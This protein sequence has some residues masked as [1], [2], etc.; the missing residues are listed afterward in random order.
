MKKKFLALSLAVLMV[1]SLLP[2]TAFAASFSKSEIS[3]PTLYESGCLKTLDVTIQAINEGYTPAYGRIGVHTE[4]SSYSYTNQYISSNNCTTWPE[5]INDP[6]LV[7]LST[8]EFLW[9]DCQEHTVTVQ[10]EDGEIPC[11]QDKTYVVHLWTR[12]EIIGIYPDHTF[13]NLVTNANGKLFFG[14]KEIVINKETITNGTPESAKETNH[15]YITVDET[16]AEG[17]NVTVTVKPNEGYQL[18]SLTC[19][20]DTPT[21][22]TI[23]DVLATVEGFPASEDQTTPPSSAWV[24]DV[25]NSRKCYAYTSS[26]GNTTVLLL[27]IPAVGEIKGTYTFF[28]T[29]TEVAKGNNYYTATNSYGSLTFNMENGILTSF[30]FTADPSK[31]NAADYVGTYTPANTPSP[32]LKPITPAKQTDGTYQFTMPG[33]AVTVTA[34]FEAATPTSPYHYTTYENWQIKHEGS[35]WTWTENLTKVEDGL[36]KMPDANWTGSGFNVASDE[37]PIK[38][39]WYAANDPDVTIGEEVIAPVIVDVY[40]RV[41]DDET[42]KIGIGEDPAPVHTHTGVKQNGQP[43]T[44]TAAG[45]KDYYKCDC[46]LYFEDEDC[47]VEIGDE[48]ALASW[49]TGEGAIAKLVHT[50]TPVSAQAATQTEAGFKDYYECVNCGKYYEDAEGKIE[51][52]DLSAWKAKGGNGYIPSEDEIDAAKTAAKAALDSENAKDALLDET[53]LTNGKSAIDNAETLDD[54]ENAKN[55]AITAIQQ[56]QASELANA[57]DAAKSALDTEEAKDPLTDKTALT[58]GKN[59]IDGATSKAA[60]EAAKNAAITAIQQAQATEHKDPKSP[61]TGDNSHTALWVMLLS[62]SSTG[63]CAC[64][65][66]GKKRKKEQ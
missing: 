64:I 25:Q 15:G 41:I 5:T 8:A 51:I 20:P 47:T 37:N 3:N 45:Y 35:E 29:T 54:I 53:A 34:E 28:P 58:N 38:K 66:L 40:L 44:E 49:K 16:A 65:V 62:L 61:E 18:K 56:A 24:A 31:P 60:V 21:I 4:V 59:S 1:V 9:T 39:D 30:E 6:T 32:R 27:R 48:T 50:I 7:G 23:A 43:A 52:T 17:E 13:G 10:F 19:T 2:M 22:S 11:N 36:F 26:S 33:Y 12:A 55:A 57:K 46:G 14:D 42:L 63:L